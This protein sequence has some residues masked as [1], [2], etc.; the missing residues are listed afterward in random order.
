MEFADHHAIDKLINRYAQYADKGD[1]KAIADH[2]ARCRL[3]FPNGDVLDV[4]A[5][6]PAAYLDWYTKLIRLYPERNTPKTRRMMGTIIIDDDGPLRAKAE[7]CVVCF[8]ATDQLPLQ[9][10]AAATFYDRFEK[11]D[12]TWWIVERR[13]DL[14]L[15]GNLTQHCWTTTL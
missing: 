2:Y 15:V 10:I 5:R 4:A 6:G 8:Q 14:E 12:G 3:I 1:F 7:S 13:E 11:I 9:P